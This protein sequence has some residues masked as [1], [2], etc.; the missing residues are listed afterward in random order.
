MSEFYGNLEFSPSSITPKKIFEVSDISLNSV[1]VPEKPTICAN[2]TRGRY[3]IDLEAY[4][5]MQPWLIDMVIL[6]RRD[7]ITGC[8]RAHSFELINVELPVEICH[9][10]IS[11]AK[12]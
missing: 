8:L 2:S 1:N 6:H 7:A 12:I 10:I 5:R 3:A 4:E 9:K 11:M